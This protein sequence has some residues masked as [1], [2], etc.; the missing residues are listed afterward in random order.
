MRYVNRQIYAREAV[1]WFDQFTRLE[2]WNRDRQQR[3]RDL[4]PEPKPEDVDK[5]MGVLWT[6]VQCSECGYHVQQAVEL[7]VI[8]AENGE[9]VVLCRNCVDPKAR[10]LFEKNEATT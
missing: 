1:K 8:D 9:P 2:P 4:G 7:N 10:S 3:L 6:S 5:I